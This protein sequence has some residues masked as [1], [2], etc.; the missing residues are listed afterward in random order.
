MYYSKTNE[1]R[2][3]NSEGTKNCPFCFYVPSTFLLCRNPKS[4]LTNIILKT[5]FSKVNIQNNPLLHQLGKALVFLG[6]IPK[7][8]HYFF[9]LFKTFG[10]LGRYSCLPHYALI[11]KRHQT[12]FLFL[13]PICNTPLDC[14][15]IGSCFLL[16]AMKTQTLALRCQ[17]GVEVS[18]SCFP[19]GMYYLLGSSEG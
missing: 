18:H 5:A 17:R 6:A 15:I 4:V 12:G 9:R 3:L 14:S 16:P 11:S 10:L 13:R 19:S 1:C 2:S 8:P 7:Q